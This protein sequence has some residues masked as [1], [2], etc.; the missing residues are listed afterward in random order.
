[1]LDHARRETTPLELL[2]VALGAAVL[3]VVMNWPLVLNLGEDIPKDLGDPL[4]QAWQVAWGGHALA[5]QPL[6]F[7]QSN[8][9]W[10][11]DDTLA[12]SDA[13][14]GYAPAGLVGSGAEAAVARYDLL[15]LFA[16]AL[17]FFGAYWLA[18]ELGVGPGPALVAGAAF[19]YAPFRLEHDGHMHVISSG[20]MALALA[21][22]VR[23]YR[24]PSPRRRGARVRGRD[25]A[26][27]ARLHARAPARL[28][29]RRAGAD[30]RRG[31]V[32]AR[33]PGVRPP[34]RRSPRSSAWCCSSDSRR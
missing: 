28:P 23:G 12:F 27:L 20:G 14:L 31:V 11:L 6:E 32:A 9:F 16:Y 26:A 5:H 10:P 33:A 34:A 7:F 30:R 8:Q 17:A 21:L 18:R 29:A 24:P 15:F 4:V 22:G 1:M 19:A 25:M 13:L 2:L 3:S